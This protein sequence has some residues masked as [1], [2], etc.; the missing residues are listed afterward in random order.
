M[1][2]SSQTGFT[3]VGLALVAACTVEDAPPPDD[4]LALRLYGQIEYAADCNSDHIDLVE[5]SVERGRIASV[6]PAFDECVQSSMTDRYTPCAGE[7]FNTA[8]IETQVAQALAITET[9]NDL[10]VTCSGGCG[11]ACAAIGTYNHSDDEAFSWG[12]WINAAVAK[13]SRPLCGPGETPD[14]TDTT[15]R[16][17]G[18]P[19]SQVASLVW[20]EVSHTHGYNHDNCGITEPGW[21]FQADTVPYIIGNCL[22]QVLSTSAEQCGEDTTCSYH[23][24]PIFEDGECVCRRDPAAPPP[25]SSFAAP[26]AGDFDND[27]VDDLAYYGLCG[28]GRIECWRVHS[29]NG[30]SFEVANFGASSWFAGD[31]PI[32]RPVVGDFD[33][34]GRDDDLAYYGLCDSGDPCW[35]VHTSNGSV[36]ATANFGAEQWSGGV[37]ATHAPL[38]GDFDNDGFRDDIA[39]SGLCGTGTPCWRVHKSDGNSFSVASFGAQMWFGG[40]DETKKPVVGDFDNDGFVDDIAY[41]GLCGSGTPCWRVHKS[42]GNAFSV[43]GYGAQ[44]WFEDDQPINAPMAGDYDAD[45]FVDD[46][47]YFG[48][49]G[50]GQSCWRV[51]IGSGSQFSAANFGGEIWFAGSDSIHAPVTGAF[52]GGGAPDDIVYYGLCS[53]NADDCWRMHRGQGTTT[54]VTSFGAGM[55]FAP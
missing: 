16:P 24:R 15:C 26:V 51:H 55:W 47:A 18:W 4:D 48:K 20:H 50:A 8:S 3:L 27:G 37:D 11:N 52:T 2:N 31:D 49:C 29:S 9:P 6:S 34:D 28:A 39:Y 43:A 42:D 12:D 22:A 23:S 32:H 33:N 46:I 17:L 1:N 19:W 45:G 30:T 13:Q 40:D 14:W 35:R 44:M 54:S 53:N 25:P 10:A 7:P 5:E 38:V 36:F 21:N 41:N